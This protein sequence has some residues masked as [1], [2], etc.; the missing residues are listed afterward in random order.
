M[1]NT[2]NP[3]NKSATIDFE[4]SKREEQAKAFSSMLQAQMQQ[5]QM[6]QTQIANTIRLSIDTGNYETKIDNLISR[7]KQ[8]TDTNGNAK[9]STDALSEAF[10]KLNAASAALSKNNTFENQQTLIQTEKELGT[11]IKHVTTSISQMT[12]QFAKNSVI[13]SLH[14]QIEDFYN[15]NGAAHSRWGLQLRNMMSETASGAQL[16]HQR[17]AEIESSFRQVSTAAG[18]SGKLGKSFFQSLKE[19]SNI[20]SHW[21]NSTYLISQ[22]FS[23]IKQ[24]LS[25]LKE[26]NT[27][28]TEISKTSDLSAGQLK[29]LGDSSYENADK[30]GIKASDY[31]TNVLKMYQAGYGNA[32]E[33]AE[34]S[35]LA[36]SAGGIDANL[37]N[38]YVIAN[39]AAFQYAGN[40]EKLTA[41]LDGQNQVTSRNAVSLE[42]LAQATKVAA[43]QLANLNISE[44]EMTAL[45]GTGIATTKE[46]AETVGRAV[47]AIIMDLQQIK[48]ETGFDS[49]VIDD[50]ALEKAEA[51][52]RSLGIEL[53]SMQNGMEKLRAPMEILKELS[54]VYNSLPDDSAEKSAI[55]S[56]IGGKYRSNVLS[57][58]LTNWD[59]YEKMLGDYQNSGGS[60]MDTAMKSA[61]NW[62][63]ALNKLSNTWTSTV[64]NI[65]DSDAAIGTVNAFDG[66]LSIVN[67]VT[68]ALGSMGTIGLGAFAFLNKGRSNMILPFMAA[69]P[70]CKF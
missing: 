17:V 37:A 33:L 53:S 22:S 55:L 61:N 32:E 65:A 28:L 66:I 42:E 51:R 9:I 36:Q 35:T 70:Y 1:A 27:I 50:K 46:S 13:S 10:Q 21:L 24:A 43:S 41:L 64:E 44:D 54:E 8:W 57:S 26:A 19:G 14:N 4:I 30:Y 60:A 23:K 16:T 38:E 39:D 47:R 58:I 45:L 15:K 69:T 40:A 56:D 48:G 25:E 29:I 34:I 11:Q 2:N 6:Q 7:T 20:F 31:L 68:S 12:A 18:Q 52:C 3:K 67:R 5:A 49:E 62:E 59:K 63:G